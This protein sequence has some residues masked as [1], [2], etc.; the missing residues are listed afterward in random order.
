MK[1]PGSQSLEAGDPR[2]VAQ[3][4][5]LGRIQAQAGRQGGSDLLDEIMRRS[6]V[7][8]TI[9]YYPGAYAD[10][11]KANKLKPYPLDDAGQKKKNAC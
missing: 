11:I 1:K 5:Y 8:E 10:T 3:G 4:Q 6:D 7:A 9:D 2:A